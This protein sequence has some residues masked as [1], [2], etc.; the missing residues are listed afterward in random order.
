MSATRRTGKRRS[1]SRDPR[2]LVAAGLVVVAL[3]VGFVAFGVVSVTGIPEVRYETL[4]VDLPAVGN[5]RP[6]DEVRVSGVR[7]GQVE[8]LEPVDNRVLAKVQLQPGTGRF[9]EDTTVAVRARGLLGSRYLE[10]IPGSSSRLLASNSVIHVGDKALTNGV[11]DVL[12][13]FDR[14]TRGGLG[15]TIGGLGQGLFGRGQ[16]INDTIKRGPGL[17]DQLTQVADSIEARDGAARRFVPSLAAAASAFDRARDDI[18]GGLGPAARGL[19][20]FVQSRRAIQST[21]DQAP[22]TLSAMSYGLTKGQ[23]LLASARSLS[24]ALDGTL[25]GAPA[26]LRST[27]RLL[28]DNDTALRRTDSLLEAAKP[29]VPAALDI[30]DSLDPNLVPL[31]HAFDD[32]RP[33][34]Q[35]LSH[36]DCDVANFADNWRSVLGYGA[37][38]E[39]KI[40]PYDAGPLNSFRIEIIAGPDSLGNLAPGI[41]EPFITDH[42][43]YAKPCKYSPGPKYDPTGLDAVTD[44]SGG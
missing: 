30:T 6:H 25:P 12:D 24:S 28:R 40:G 37:P 31:T 44:R 16:E 26:A 34:G 14:Q 15:S 32:L 1:E 10:I 13:V 4:N 35:T 3:A 39:R 36:H 33:I 23:T 42:D 20:P 9:S 11:S 5:L 27:T 38:S 7:V 29:A 19:D 21:L 43:V 22:S 18:A 2:K 17:A 41:A 8:A